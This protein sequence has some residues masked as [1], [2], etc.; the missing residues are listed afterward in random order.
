MATFTSQ[1]II[2]FFLGLA[3]LLGVARAVGELALRYRQPVIVGEIFGGILLGPAVFGY[4]APEFSGWLLPITGGAST[5][6]EGL[7]V[8][9]AALLLLVAGLE[10]ELSLIWRQGRGVLSTSLMG[11]VLPFGVG[12][13]A[14][15]LFPGSIGQQH[16]GA[17]QRLFALFFGTALTISALPVIAKTLMD[18]NLFKSRVGM[19]VMAAAMLDDLVGWIFFSVLL[20]L[21]SAGG[22]SGMNI[23]WTIGLTIG[24]TVLLLT[25]G[26]GAANRVLPWV[27]ER[28]TWPGGV[29]GFVLV[30]ALAG[31]AATEAIGIH[32]VFGAFLVGIAIGDSK[33]LDEKTRDIVKQFVLNFFAPLYFVSIGLKVNFAAHFDVALIMLVL[34]LGCLSKVVGSGL[35]AYWGGFGKREALAVGFGM[36]ARG[37]MQ[38]IFGTLAFE[39]GLIGESML[40]AFVVMALVTSVL[41][42]PMMERFMGQRR[43]QV[44][45]AELVSPT[46]SG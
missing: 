16:I 32:A 42:G 1:D 30:S 18:L 8:L 25:A 29:L 36:N 19:V 39:H 40:V 33:Q 44:V 38:I 34:A 27:R 24:F 23:G 28:L 35:G 17:D 7:T 14:V 3:V 31:A 9:S 13:A 46:G 45:G 15:W 12:F 2:T 22:L 10:V 41:A 37:M 5:V 4:V 20:G 21:S 26:R 6:F 11:F 43:Q